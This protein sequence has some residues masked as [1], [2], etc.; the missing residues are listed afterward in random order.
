MDTF[1]VAQSTGF[2]RVCEWMQQREY[3][4]RQASS[5]EKGKEPVWVWYVA[6]W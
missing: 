1:P 3:L 6:L 5:G 2:M 4:S